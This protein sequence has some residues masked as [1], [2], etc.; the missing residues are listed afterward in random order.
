MGGKAKDRK[1]GSHKAHMSAASGLERSLGS[2]L[3]LEM[4]WQCQY[5]I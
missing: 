5:G 2:S 1:G 4:P 3:G